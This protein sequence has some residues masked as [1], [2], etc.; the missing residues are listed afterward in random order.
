MKKIGVRICSILSVLLLA[1]NPAIAVETTY[2]IGSG[3]R[4]RCLE[5][6]YAT[7]LLRVNRRS[8]TTTAIPFAAAIKKNRRRVRQLGRRLR[9]AQSRSEEKLISQLQRKIESSREIVTGIKDCR[10]LGQ[11]KPAP[12][13]PAP[14]GPSAEKVNACEVIGEG[15]RSRAYQARIINGDRCQAPLSPTVMVKLFSDGGSFFGQCSGVAVAPKAVI[16]AAHCLPPG[17]SVVTVVSGNEEI[18]ADFFRGHPGFLESYDVLE[19]NDIGIILLRHQ[20]PGKTVQ[21]LQSNNLTPGEIGVIGGFGLDES[22]NHSALRAAPV[23]IHSSTPA[24]VTITYSG[25]DENG[26]TCS[27]DSGGPLLVERR[28]IWKLA[29]ITSNGRNVNCG[30]GDISNFANISD[31]SNLSFIDEYVEELGVK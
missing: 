26:N 10:A 12:P 13:D 18:Q 2:D 3:Q 24:S 30:P 11:D 9:G 4:Y 16:T 8:A 1:T 7:T 25:L 5:T 23:T 15:E 21:I 6:E 27:G 22:G 17:L 29:G 31:P 28:G 20:L 14:S 19:K